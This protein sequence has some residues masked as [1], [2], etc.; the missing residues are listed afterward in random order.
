MTPKGHDIQQHAISPR[1]KFN[2]MYFMAF[3]K[4]KLLGK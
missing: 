4:R 3:V 2:H 1:Y